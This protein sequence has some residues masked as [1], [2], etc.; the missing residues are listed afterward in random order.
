[1][2]S[3]AQSFTNGLVAYY[4]FNGN[5]NDAAG[6]NNGTIHGGVALAPDRFGSNNSAYTFNGVDGYIDIG[7][8]VGNSPTHLTEC[9]WVKIISRANTPYGYPPVDV[10]ITKRQTAYIGSGW[11][12]LGIGSG[13]SGQNIGEG[14][15]IVE[16][17]NYIN[18][19]FGT[20]QT[21]TN[22]WF[23]ICGIK[24]NNTYQIYINGALEN[25]ITDSTPLSSSEDMYLM[26]HGAWGAYSHGV[27]DDVRIYN[28]ALSSNEVAQIYAIETAAPTAP[29]ITAQP[30]NVTVNVGDTASFT[31][32]A[33]GAAPLGYQWSFNT[34]NIAGAT[35]ATL[36]L[37]NVQLNQ[38]GNYSVLV[39]N[40]VGSTNSI[41]ATL[42]VNIPVCDPPPSGLV[43]WWAA[44][45]NA[46]DQIG[47]IN[48]TP[49]GN[50]TYGPGQAG[51]AFVGDGISSGISMSNSPSL[52][53][54]NFTIEAWIKRSSTTAVASSTTA[55][56]FGYG[57]NGYGFGLWNN[58][59]LFITKVGV[60]SM[61]A[62]TS[63]TDTNFH[64]VAVTKNGSTVIFYVDGVGYPPVVY[65]T[66]FTFTAP[67]GIAY[68]P[69][70]ATCSFLG[71]M[72]EVSV[73]NRPLLA[74][75]IQG[76]HL[77]GS[78]GKCFTPNHPPAAD[79]TATIPL[80]ISLNN[81]NATVVLDGSLSSDPD[82]D[83][84]QYYW[85]EN[86]AATTSATGI[87]AVVV[88]PL[89]TNSITL[90]VSDGQASNQQTIAVQVITTA[91]AVERLIT[92][93]NTDVSKA[94]PLAAILSAAI[95]AIGRSNPTAAINQL[96][97]FQN[98]V[99]AQIAPLDPAL[100]DTLIGDAQAI[101]DALAGGATVHGNVAATAQHAN[102][103]L[104][105][106]FSATHGQVYIIEAST[107]LVDWHSI[108]V[109]KDQGDGTFDFDDA[110]A[111]RMRERFYR[112]ATP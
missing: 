4:P 76:I 71:V 29:T 91:E 85:F 95:K 74:S 111:A 84:L 105:L 88:L 13:S 62:S 49:V 26:H 78:A 43:S 63:I 32:T 33:S 2:T 3:H 47:G 34:T 53:L 58:G 28:R 82:G 94:Q 60:D 45:G 110:D 41:A 102:G 109:A 21:P 9:A 80:V 57:N 97:A 79:A 11:P 51:Q 99:R 17:D 39:A 24:S 66:T 86:S 6:A 8:P 37:N 72:D 93:V 55:W 77:A 15:I 14:E 64:H 38:A 69:G 75:E 87:V 42:T 70:N 40:I 103:K 19:D 23:F 81:S 104:H 44:E 98:K 56:L 90:S 46:L 18:P 83:S 7:N 108:G 68:L 96:Q 20:S 54:Q 12:T 25:T 1:M 52:Q 36:T 5:A 67:M 10:I 30:T 16:A 48:G 106:K 73:Y 50:L 22:V 107:N 61:S 35:N 27:L 92:L 112:V 89:G 100:A 65:N 59:Q 101:I 31:V